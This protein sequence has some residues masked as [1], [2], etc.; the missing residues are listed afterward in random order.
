LLIVIIFVIL[1]IG[2]YK[3]TSTTNRIYIGQT[4]N[5]EK[6]VFNY[7]RLDCKSQR[8]LYN[9][10]IKYG[11]NEH[12]FEFIDECLESELNNRERYWQDYYDVISSKGLN[13]RLQEADGKSGVFSEETKVKMS[14]SQIGKK[15]S[16]ETKA[17]ISLSKIGLKY[18]KEINLKKG[19]KGH[20]V[21]E[22]TR[23]KLSNSLKGKNF[24]IERIENLKKANK[25]KRS[26]VMLD[27]QTGIFYT[28]VHEVAE[29]TGFSLAKVKHIMDGSVKNKT[30]LI[31]T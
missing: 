3:I 22:E 16:V 15:T 10:F 11:V 26:V 31:R 19:R 23:L 28:G 18:S 9:S 13:C 8:K 30:N 4:V 7:K 24:S 27:T 17:K 5:Y 2:I 1:V 21:T 29:I 25:E 20:A 6:R 12:V 14:I